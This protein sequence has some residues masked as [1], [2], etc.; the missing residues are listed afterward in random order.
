MRSKPLRERLAQNPENPLFKFSLGQA[1]FEENQFQEASQYLTQCAEGRA[2]WM[3]PRILA[4]KALVELKQFD[5]AKHFFE[6]A[7]KLAIEQKHDDPAAEL[8]ELLEQL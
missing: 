7:L 4:G 1:L 2:D 6:E 5:K 8:R 3:L